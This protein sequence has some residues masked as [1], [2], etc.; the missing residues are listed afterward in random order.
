MRRLPTRRALIIALVALVLFLAA[1]TAQAGWLF[2]LAA[3]VLGLVVGSFLV[4]PPLSA[5]AVER[6]VPRR[7]RV[8][9]EVRVGLR[10]HN[11]GRR[12]LPIMRLEDAFAAFD[13][14]AVFVERV[15]AGSSATIELVKKALRR[16]V[17]SSGSARLQTGSPAGLVRTTRSVDVVS[18]MTVVPRWVELRSFPILEPS[19]FPFDVLHERARTGAGEEYL[20]VRGYRPGDPPRWVHWKSSARAGHLVVREFEE[21]VASRVALV[22]AGADE[23]V[24]PDSAF[25]AIVEA[26]ASIARYAIVTGHPVDLVRADPDGSTQ[27]VVEP[28]R[29]EVLDWLAEAQPVDAPMDELTGVALDRVGRRGTVVLLATTSGRAGRSLRTAAAL[30]QRAGSRAIVV[31]AVSSSWSRKGSKVADEDA[32]LL[33][34]EGGRAAVRALIRGGDLAR[35]LEASRQTVGGRSR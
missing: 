21:E 13:E 18:E 7:V 12:T 9:D 27:Q 19:S 10:V 14:T 16:G 31:A 26:A 2:V 28:D 5:A 24:P 33:E 22:V 8:G 32:S 15:P 3:G 6:S 1:T 17:Y 34:L 35:D 25:E 30:A 20:G 11:S 23:G 29:V 4:R